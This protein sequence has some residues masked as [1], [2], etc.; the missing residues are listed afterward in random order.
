MPKTKKTK[1]TRARHVL[2]VDNKVECP[3]CHKVIQL[4]P[5]EGFY[6]EIMGLYEPINPCKHF[7]NV[8]WTALGGSLK[9]RFEKKSK[10]NEKC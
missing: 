7:V 5:E 3:F 1:K 8:F 4:K 9:V 10:T 6:G 2:V